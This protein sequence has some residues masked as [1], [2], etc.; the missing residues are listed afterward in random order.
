MEKL[1]DKACNPNEVSPLTLAFLGDG[2]YDLLVRDYL[3]TQA[4]RPV[5]K[6]NKLKIDLVCC[7]AQAQ[8]AEKLMGRLTEKELAVYKRGRNANSSSTPK[9]ASRADYHSATGLEAMFGYLYL[10][11]EAQRI[12]ELFSYIIKEFSCNTC[13][14]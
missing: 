4:N 1:I 2:V 9:N 3:V 13:T 8:I 10:N 7:K 5:G 11:N 12:K 14:G 6:L